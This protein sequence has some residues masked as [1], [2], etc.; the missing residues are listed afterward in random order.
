[1]GGPGLLK[2][3]LEALAGVR[4]EIATANLGRLLVRSVQTVRGRQI[5]ILLLIVPGAVALSAVFVLGPGSHWAW[6]LVPTGSAA[7][8]GVGGGLALLLSVVALS[9]GVDPHPRVDADD[10]GDDQVQVWISFFALP[11]PSAPSVLA[12]VVFS[13]WD[14][15]WLT[16]PVGGLNGAFV[17]WWLGRVAHRR[18]APRPPETF[19]RI[20][21]GRAIALRALPDDGSW[22]ERLERAAVRGDAETRPTGS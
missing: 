13:P 7:L 21:Y 18:P 1:M 9:P 17:S 22:L 8:L 12:A 3:S 4:A 2:G 15:P 11:L 14:L 10:T 16:V 20:R 5:A 6:P 19:T